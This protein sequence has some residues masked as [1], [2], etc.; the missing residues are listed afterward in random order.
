MADIDPAADR[1]ASRA[2]A[3]RLTAIIVG[4]GMSGLLAAIRLKREGIHSFV[5][6]EKAEDVGGTWLHNRYPGA[7]CD[8]PSHLYSYSFRPKPDWSRMFAMQPE[9]L[10]Y[11][12]DTA[13]EEGLRAHIALRTEVSAARFEEAQGL[14]HVEAKDG[15]RWDARFLVIA[16]GQLNKPRVPDIPGRRDFAG[17]Q[18][19][20]AEWNEAAN[21]EGKNVV[22]VGTG[23]SAV[24][25]VPPVADQAKR[26]TVIQ[27]SP[28]WLVPRPDREFSRR[29]KAA[30][31]LLPPLR[32]LLRG[33]IYL[34]NELN[35]HAMRHPDGIIARVMERRARK[36]LEEQVPDPE[37]RRQLTPDYPIG[38]KRIL[39]ASDYYPALMRDNVDLESDAVARVH[40]TGVELESGKRIP[41]E[42][43]IWGTGFDTASFVAPIEVTGRNGQRLVEVWRDG[44]QG[45]KGTLVSGFP[46]MA[47]LYG[48]N[49]NL[50]HN[51]IIFMAERQMDYVMKIIRHVLGKDLRFVDV[52]EEVE[53]RWNEALQRRLGRTVWAAGCDSWYKHD[54][55][56][57]NNWSSSTLRFAWELRSFDE[58][59]FE[60]AGWPL[61]AGQELTA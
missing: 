49:T 25:F 41:A 29:T 20:S 13:A 32:L 48:P 24:Q 2:P 21:V 36:H 26:L 47:V 34:T 17:I 27:R 35:F 11:F 4:A 18:F 19:H 14:W 6:L 10:D 7:S 53:D 42:I 23:A 57:I 30:F 5:V 54:G 59:R 56:I 61:P 37:L 60:V 45:Y 8:I 40:Q 1:L 58:R 22:A 44:A 3:P 16:T 9:I 31:G 39:I 33:Y 50:G 38:C 28:N 15:R 52:R 55:K 46:N 12:R 43:I 51:S